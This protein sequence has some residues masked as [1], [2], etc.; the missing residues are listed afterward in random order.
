MVNNCHSYFP[1]II[2]GLKVLSSTAA[3]QIKAVVPLTHIF[4]FVV[5]LSSGD[6]WVRL[7]EEIFV[8]W[9]SSRRGCGGQ[10]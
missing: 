5:V 2:T 3:R 10:G 8:S 7:K 4:F 9:Y 6:L 1:W